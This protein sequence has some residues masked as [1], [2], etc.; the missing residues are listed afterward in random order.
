MEELP[1]QFLDIT[2]ALPYMVRLGY[3][4]AEQV[5]YAIRKKLYREGIDYVDAKMPDAAR[6][7]YRI[8]PARCA[9]QF[10]KPP[11]K[12]VSPHKRGRP[13]KSGVA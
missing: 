2:D 3:H 7:T 10:V 6:S 1:N 4:N 5:R 9:E 12:R 13:S 8:N 11:H